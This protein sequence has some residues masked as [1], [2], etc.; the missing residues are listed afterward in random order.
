MFQLL[1]D[2]CGKKIERDER[3]TEVIFEEKRYDG[4]ASFFIKPMNLKDS[5][6][7]CNYCAHRVYELLNFHTDRVDF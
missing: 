5:T 4:N 1:C 7:L 2:K 3:I 6:T